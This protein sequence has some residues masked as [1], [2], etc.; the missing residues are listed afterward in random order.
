MD[1]QYLLIITAGA[2][3]GGRGW[4]GAWGGERWRPS[5]PGRAP[6]M[7]HDIAHLINQSVVNRQMQLINRI[8]QLSEECH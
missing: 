7:S 4:V 5:G 3:A 2:A 1:Y 8:M 6:A